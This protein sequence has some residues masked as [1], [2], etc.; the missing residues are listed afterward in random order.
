MVLQCGGVIVFLLHTADG[1]DHAHF[2]A[3]QYDRQNHL[4]A[5][6]GP[7]VCGV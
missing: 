1:A 5:A 4:R 2:P 3:G 6:D 7:G